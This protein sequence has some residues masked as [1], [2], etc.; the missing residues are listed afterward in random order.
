MAEWKQDGSRNWYRD[1]WGAGSEHYAGTV[2]WTGPTR[3]TYLYGAT[4]R[5]GAGMGSG[6][7][8]TLEAAMAAC[9]ALIDGRHGGFSE[10]EREELGRTAYEAMATIGP[11]SELWPH[12]RAAYRAQGEA[13]AKVALRLVEQRR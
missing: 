8:D 9:D 2:I 7:A 10:A 13:V 5:D 4:S 11:W 6:T 1:E 12:A 3:D